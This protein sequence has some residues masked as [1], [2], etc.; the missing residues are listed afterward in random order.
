MSIWILLSSEGAHIST[1]IMY[2]TCIIS[3]LGNYNDMYLYDDFQTIKRTHMDFIHDE[4][5][6]NYSD[7]ND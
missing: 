6:Y 3:V 2:D 1:Y 4:N 5:W 7:E